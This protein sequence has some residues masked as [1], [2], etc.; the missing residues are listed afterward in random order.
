LLDPVIAGLSSSPSGRQL[1]WSGLEQGRPGLL[2]NVKMV[3]QNLS[4]FKIVINSTLQSSGSSGKVL[5]GDTKGIEILDGRPT[6]Q[7]CRTPVSRVVF[8]DEA[9]STDL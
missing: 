8:A 1:L 6:F 2:R 7:A 3:R 4:H 5:H 9:I